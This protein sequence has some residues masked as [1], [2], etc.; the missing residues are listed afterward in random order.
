MLFN[1]LWALA[2]YLLLCALIVPWFLLPSALLL[3]FGPR[4]VRGFLAATRDMQ[5]IESTSSSPMYQAFSQALQ[6]VVTLRAFGAEAQAAAHM[7]DI[8]STTMALWWAIAT[9]DVWCSFRSQILGGVSVFLATV[10]AITGTVS[11][12]S[13]GIVMSS[14]TLITQI[15]LYLTVNWK[16]LSNNMN[17]ME[18][19]IEYMDVESEIKAEHDREPPAAWPSRQATIAVE[20]LSMR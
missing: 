11:P 12:G 14:A 20:G 5:R 1:D 16:N 15:C 19:V 17:S 8:T 3:A 9:S 7:R 2:T 13:A 10:L 18:R 6:G 4:Y